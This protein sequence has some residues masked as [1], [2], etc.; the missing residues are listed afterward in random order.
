MIPSRE[1]QSPFILQNQRVVKDQTDKIKV[2]QNNVSL[3]DQLFIAMQSRDSDIDKLLV[4][5]IQSYPPSLSNLRKLVLYVTSLIQC[6][7][8]KANLQQVHQQYLTAKLWIGKL[9]CIV[10][11]PEW[12]AHS[13]RIQSKYSFHI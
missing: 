4:H 9:L 10:S 12:C 8:S 5:E 7:A 6:I 11:L 13:T 3:F 1:T 2:L